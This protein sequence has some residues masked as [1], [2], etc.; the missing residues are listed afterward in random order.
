MKTQNSILAVL[1]LAGWTAAQ[2]TN[3]TVDPEELEAL[4][5]NIPECAKDCIVEYAGA[6]GCDTDFSQES[7]TCIC[8]NGETIKTTAADC[9]DAACSSDELTGKFRG[10]IHKRVPFPPSVL[11][12]LLFGLFFLVIVL[13]RRRT[14]K[15]T[16]M[17]ND[18]GRQRRKRK[19]KPDSNRLL[20]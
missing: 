4:N 19:N 16:K 15:C 13:V 10:I 6:L 8:E 20:F 1:G 17:G 2:S 14:N 11:D 9:L 12:F 5:A 3:V 18:R 7:D